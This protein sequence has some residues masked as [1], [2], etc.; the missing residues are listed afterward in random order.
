MSCAPLV[1]GLSAMGFMLRR[2]CI[3]APGRS[4]LASKR[5]SATGR[6]LRAT[7]FQAE[8]RTRL[9]RCSFACRGERWMLRPMDPI[10]AGRRLR[11]A[12]AQS[13]GGM[14]RRTGGRQRIDDAGFLRHHDPHFYRARRLRDLAAALGARAE[15]RQRTA[16]LRSALAP[17][18][19]R[20][21]P[22]TAPRRAGDNVVRLPGAETAPR[23]R[24]RS[25]RGRA[26][27]GHR[28]A[29]HADGAARSTRSPRRAEL[30]CRASFSKAPSRPT[31]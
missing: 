23:R 31:R 7:M 19:R 30:R 10:C 24:R 6:G 4:A 16:A 15:D 2:E 5:G 12:A 3:V 14:P 26:L 28:R 20:L 9:S 29:R 11:L 17:R 27:E 22:A 8:Q 18:C 13:P 1:A 25:R 21:R